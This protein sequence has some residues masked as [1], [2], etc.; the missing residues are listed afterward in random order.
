MVMQRK[1]ALLRGAASNAH[2][3]CV[4]RYLVGHGQRLMLA[5]GFDLLPKTAAAKAIIAGLPLAL[6]VKGKSMSS[7]SG[8]C[9]S[10]GE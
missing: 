10:P 4:F 9:L 6:D 2:V 5:V 1:K 8:G 7:S 3:C